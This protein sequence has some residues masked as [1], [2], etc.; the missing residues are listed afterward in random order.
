MRST[1]RASS[2]RAVKTLRHSSFSKGVRSGS[3][4][5]CNAMD[6][7]SSSASAES[8]CPV[9]RESAMKM[10]SMPMAARCRMAKL[11]LVSRCSSRVG[12][13]AFKGLRGRAKLGT[14]AP[15]FMPWL[16]R[17]RV[18]A[19]VNASESPVFSR[20]K[21]LWRASSLSRQQHCCCNSSRVSSF[22]TEAL[23]CKLMPMPFWLSFAIW[24]AVK[25]S[26]SRRVRSPF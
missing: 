8:S 10:Q 21:K 14:K 26:S 6:A 7:P 2:G 13:P 25:P 22:K 19:R 16:C 12:R 24:A 5:G 15:V 20:G 9:G 3:H 18:F 4:S 23:S 1:S 17:R 11:K